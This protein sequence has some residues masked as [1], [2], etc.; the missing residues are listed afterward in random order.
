MNIAF[1]I[2]LLGMEGLGATL[3]SLL[4]HC[5]DHSKLKLHFLCSKV[6]RKHKNNIRLLLDNQNFKGK[7]IFFDFDAKK[8]FGHLRSLHGDW[9][10]YGRLLIPKL[11]P[12]EKVLYLDTDVLVLTDVLKLTNFQ[13]N[14]CALAAVRGGDTKQSVDANFYIHTLYFN[15]K[16][17]VFNSGVLLFDTALWQQQNIDDQLQ[18]ICDQHAHRFISADQTLLNAIFQ[19]DFAYLPPC[20]NRRWTPLDQAIKITSNSI[21][22]FV[23]SPKPWDLF[24]KNIHDA[25]HLWEF[26]NPKFWERT[27]NQMNSQKLYRTWKIKKSIVRVFL[28]K[29]K[30]K[31]QRGY[32][33]ETAFQST[34]R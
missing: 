10:P 32:K 23:G 31:S 33:E 30:R 16:I 27:Y 7:I 34:N 1:N 20:Y 12:N 26:Y 17:Q 21:I 28:N 6:T 4:D 15:P 11:L 8:E 22:H 18:K 3:T 24:G 9:T 14:N 19:G 29:K 5:S 25:Y 2:N 13:Q